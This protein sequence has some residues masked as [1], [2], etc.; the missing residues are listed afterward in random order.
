MKFS[1]PLAFCGAILTLGFLPS[2]RAAAVLTFLNSGPD[3]VETGSGTLNLSAL[4]PAGIV[5]AAAGVHPIFGTTFVGIPAVSTEDQYTGLTGPANF[6]PGG[7]TFATS[8]SGNK[9]GVFFNGAFFLAVP[10]GYI[11]GTALAGTSTY[12]GK[13]LGALGATPGT[14]IYAWGS[15]ATADSLTVQL[16]LA[17]PE[18]GT[19]ASACAAMALI[20]SLRHKMRTNH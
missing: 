17:A 13:S 1:Q 15:G 9:F 2:A 3:V 14:Y 10:A 4:S 7:T 16:G 18:P 11:S 6:G 8:G 12:A 20:F 5:G 19:L